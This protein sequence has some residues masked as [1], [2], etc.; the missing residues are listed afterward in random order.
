MQ[1]D[2]AWSFMKIKG[3]GENNLALGEVKTLN[4]GKA[5]LK[6]PNEHR[7]AVKERA[8][9]IPQQYLKKAKDADIKYNNGNPCV[10]H[11]LRR[12]GKI[13]SLVFGSYGVSFG[14]RFYVGMVHIFRSSMF[15]NSS[16]RMERIRISRRK[17]LQECIDV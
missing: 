1:P 10:E 11:E 14:H 4:A 6:K 16:K 2:L 17:I 13:Q 8:R 15:N 7:E 5:Y 9:K 3:T 12:Y